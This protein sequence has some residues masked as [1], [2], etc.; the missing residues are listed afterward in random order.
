LTAHST[1]DALDG[2][3]LRD[4]ARRVVNRA[5]NRAGGTRA[6]YD[7]WRLIRAGDRGIQL[8]VD[9]VW[10]AW[11]HDPGRR[12]WTALSRWRR[13]ADAHSEL[14]GGLRTAGQ[15][16]ALSLAALDDPA[17][18]TSADGL[19]HAM[20]MTGHPIADIARRR[21]LDTDGRTGIDDICM[22]A[23]GSP[24]VVDFLTRHGL[25]PVSE[26][27]AA[28]Y[29]LL[30]DQQQ[31]YWEYDPDQALLARAY[32]EL[33]A[34]R[35]R[36]RHSI[37]AF[38]DVDPL[39]VL[40]TALA[41]VTKEPA[42]VTYVAGRLAG[43]H[44]WDGLWR[45]ARSLPPAEASQ[46]L[47]EA[48]P[49]WRPS[50]LDEAE[51]Y[52]L[53]R[54][55]DT[56]SL[57]NRVTALGTPRRF[58]ADGRVLHGAFSAD[59]AR[60]AMTVRSGSR[61]IVQVLDLESETLVETY[62]L[63]GADPGPVSFE[64]RRPIVCQPWPGGPAMTSTVRRLD[65]RR[66][67]GRALPGWAM[68]LRPLSADGTVQIALLRR[69]PQSRPELL[70]VR[71]H[72][73]PAIRPP[74]LT[75]LSWAAPG[76]A[77]P[78]SVLATDPDS[79]QIA[80]AGTQ[81]LVAG[82]GRGNRMRGLAYRGWT[83]AA[84]PYR[85]MCFDGPQHLIVS[86]DVEVARFRIDG[87]GLS[88]VA[89]TDAVHGPVVRVPYRNAVAVADPGEGI[90]Y[91]DAG[92]L[93]RQDRPDGITGLRG[94]PQLWASPSGTHAACLDWQTIHLMPASA[95][96][97]ADLARRPMNETVPA[98]AAILAAARRHPA[99]SGRAGVL[100]DIL[101]ANQHSDR[102]GPGARSEPGA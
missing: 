93:E 86:D 90:V 56:T 81:I 42:E 102:A 87:W 7:S 2:M 61:T 101:E 39:R 45:F 21:I 58:E 70:L 97:L 75:H 50:D 11:L 68:D 53:L 57:L 8:A 47:Q 16:H 59:D 79:G 5:A 51:L 74:R 54:S 88:P 27:A 52:L 17:L 48:G 9:A 10:Q 40:V 44:D 64:G 28:A 80:V 76:V 84:R 91:L 60:A 92:T 65:A 73:P 34:L 13:P 78:T 23:I 82:L 14:P 3:Q 89:R 46:A 18:G 62:D 96:L 26:P 32:R 49:G 6:A 72:G 33:P 25:Q 85:S 36:L 22:A 67:P 38:G 1:I 69:S 29:L 15:V 20:T 43:N 41:G 55:T 63:G 31:R 71:R 37:P 30:T 24:D 95:G 94:A 66:R 19:V 99:L 4:L 100:L 98:R 77:T 12:W 83:G 35:S